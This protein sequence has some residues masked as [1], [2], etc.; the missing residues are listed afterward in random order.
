VKDHREGSH[1]RK[2]HYSTRRP[3]AIPLRDPLRS[4][5]SN[6]V[7]IEQTLKQTD[8]PPVESRN[9]LHSATTA[10]RRR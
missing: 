4:E 9:E 7:A 2:P 1:R 8:V 6:I 5:L 10:V 3:F